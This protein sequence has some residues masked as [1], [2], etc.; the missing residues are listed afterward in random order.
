MHC[1]NLRFHGVEASFALVSKEWLLILHN[2]H[3]LRTTLVVVR[4]V[5]DPRA[6]VD[7]GF[8]PHPD[9]VRPRNRIRVWAD[10][11]HDPVSVFHFD[12]E[13]APN[14]PDWDGAR[15]WQW[16]GTMTS[17]VAAGATFSRRQSVYVNEVCHP[18]IEDF[19]LSTTVNGRNQFCGADWPDVLV[20]NVETLYTFCPLTLWAKEWIDEH[21]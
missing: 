12:P 14:W 20:N 1:P 19:G 16:H 21:V 7:A 2:L 3:G 17:S 8:Y 4:H 15:D 10:A 11:T 6:L 18:K 9:L 13:E 5:I